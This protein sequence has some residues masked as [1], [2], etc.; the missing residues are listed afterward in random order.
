MKKLFFLPAVISLITLCSASAQEQ[1][2]EIKKVTVSDFNVQTGLFLL[3]SEGGTM[4]DFKALAPNSDL[5]NMNFSDYTSYSGFT[6]SGSTLFAASVGLNFADKQKSS[7]KKNPQLRIGIAFANT[8]VF[9]GGYFKE[10][11]KPYDTLVSSQS[12]L[13]TYIDSLTMKSVNVNYS[14]E[15]LRM[16]AS[17]I[18]RTNQ[19]KRWSLYTGI[20]MSAGWAINAYTGVSYFVSR[21]TQEST[22]SSYSGNAGETDLVTEHFQ[23]K[24]GG[25]F[26]SYLPLG[27]DFRI[28]KKR[29]F[30]QHLHLYYEIK[31]SVNV[32]MIPELKTFI[33]AGVQEGLGIRYTMN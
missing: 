11:R 27:I 22:N 24:T 10:E 20:G 15:Q 5:L 19:E 8:N 14:S 18:F 12:G 2:K 23:N 16:D 9:G 28:G 7:Y 33:N 25:G 13:A 17:L 30:W 29:E 21:Q 32:T 26:S 6:I 4:Q 1:A 31:P 3:K